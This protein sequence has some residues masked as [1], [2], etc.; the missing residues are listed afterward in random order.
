MYSKPSVFEFVV[1][2]VFE[3]SP[4]LEFSQ[5]ASYKLY[6]E[7]EVPAGGI[8]TGIG[9]VSGSATLQILLLYSSRESQSLE[10]ADVLKM[11]VFVVYYGLHV[12]LSDAY[13][14]YLLTY[15]LLCFGSTEIYKLQNRSFSE[16][17][18]YEWLKVFLD[19]L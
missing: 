7:E 3:R 4:F 10:V 8:I 18:R 6:G 2:C 9:R 19:A 16:F 5:L 17:L 13:K 14:G 1:A 15:L 11:C 12:R